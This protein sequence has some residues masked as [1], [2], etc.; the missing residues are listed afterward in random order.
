MQELI[1][2]GLHYEKDKCNTVGEMR[3]IKTTIREVE[4]NNNNNRA[5]YTQ[6]QIGTL[7]EVSIFSVKLWKTKMRI[8]KGQPKSTK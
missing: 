6:K 5:M 2:L 1:I 4:F 8:L 3:E 7:K